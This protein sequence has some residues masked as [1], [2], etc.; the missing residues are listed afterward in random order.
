MRVSDHIQLA[1]LQLISGI[2]GVNGSAGPAADDCFGYSRNVSE[3]P[4]AMSERQLVDA[5]DRHAMPR[6]A[7]ALKRKKARK[8]LVAVEELLSALAVVI[9]G[10]KEVET[11]R[12]LA[13]NPHLQRVIAF[14]RARR[15]GLV[16]SGVLRKWLEQTPQRNL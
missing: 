3:Q 11:A 14:M 1:E 6:P 15:I 13:L 12:E 7:G 2:V 10:P 4:P 16:H 9:V 8:F 5:G